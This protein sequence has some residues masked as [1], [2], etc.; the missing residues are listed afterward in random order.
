MGILG[1]AGVMGP[2]PLALMLSVGSAGLAT[3]AAFMDA[4]G[5]THAPTIFY[6][7]GGG[8]ASREAHERVIAKCPSLLAP[9]VP[10]PFLTNPHVETI[11]ASKYRK[12]PNVQYTR[13]CITMSDGGTV[14]LDWEHNPQ[15]DQTLHADAPVLILLP[16]LTGGSCDSYVM[17][18]VKRAASRGMRAVVFNGRGT[19]ESPVTVPQYY[20][21]SFTGDMRA[22]VDLVHKRYPSASLVAAGWSLGANILVRYLGEEGR[23]SPLVAAVSMCNPFD[24]VISNNHFEKGF[25]RI[26]DLNLA[27]SLKKIHMK[28]LRIW[29]GRNLHEKGFDLPLAES[30]KTIREF[31]E[32]ITIHSFGWPSVNE[33]Y[34]GSS[35]SL[36]IPHV[37]KPLLCIQALDD[38]IA[39]QEAIPYE[40]LSAN[41]C[42]V[43]VT[44]ELGGHLGWCAG[45]EGPRKHPWSDRPMIEWLEAA[46]QECKY[47]PKDGNA[48]GFKLSETELEQDTASV[49]EPAAEGGKLTAR[50]SSKVVALNAVAR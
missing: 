17:Y 26:Y 18:A 40:A 23:A 28:H 19:A 36:S 48:C 9:Y 3:L 49:D 4:R 15:P 46:I 27:N 20:S 21:A 29:K 37:M 5:K 12:S 41:P 24:L 42:T 35:S 16:G 8:E 38:P 47:G 50:L 45:D 22:V 1:D 33:Y 11:F 34:K 13:E 7:T 14:A 32:A 30:C 25:N 10:V 6:P 43:L 39:P 31:D 44:T 2:G